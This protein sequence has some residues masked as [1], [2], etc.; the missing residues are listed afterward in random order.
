MRQPADWEACCKKGRVSDIHPDPA[1]ISSLLSSSEASIK[2]ARLLPLTSDTASDKIDLAYKALRLLLEALSSQRGY[3]ISNHE[4]YT[5]FL[6]EVM[7]C[8]EDGDAFDRFRVLRNNINY[9][10]TRVSVEDA[11][12][13]SPQI[14][15]LRTRLKKHIQG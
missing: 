3:K 7:K 8:G 11:K 6:K 1:L 5:A 12:A 14:E 2:S 10:G 4:C 15:E 9:Y 13:T